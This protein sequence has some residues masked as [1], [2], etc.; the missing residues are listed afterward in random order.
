MAPTERENLRSVDLVAL[1][2]IMGSEYRDVE[3]LF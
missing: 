3:K 1:L 2:S